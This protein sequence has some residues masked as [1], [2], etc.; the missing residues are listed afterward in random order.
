MNK[1][2]VHLFT[3]GTFIFNIKQ[4]S[5]MQIINHSVYYKTTNLRKSYLYRLPFLIKMIRQHLIASLM[6]Y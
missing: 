3:K 6:L 2:N 4:Y 5:I 1:M